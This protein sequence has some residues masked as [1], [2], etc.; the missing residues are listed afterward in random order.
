[1]KHPAELALHQYLA[2]AV[3]GKS[4]ISEETI[5]RI[6]KDL[7]MQCADSLVVGHAEKSSVYVCPT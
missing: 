6:G 2:D 7:L 1:M 4:T 5:E 3:N